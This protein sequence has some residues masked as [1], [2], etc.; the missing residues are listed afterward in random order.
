LPKRAL[1]AEAQAFAELADIVLAT[2][3]KR[4]AVEVAEGPLGR[5]RALGLFDPFVVACRAYPRLV[6]LAIRGGEIEFVTEA[7]TRSRDF[8]LGRKY[9]LQMQRVRSS[10]TSQLSAREEEVLD[11]VA[12]GRTNAEVARLLFISPVTVK[13]HLRHI[14]EKLG[15][16]NRVEAAAHLKRN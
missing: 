16:R 14:Y 8:D 6:E 11:L 2:N 5:I 4:D 3:S 9:G 7:L 1:H 13:A 10:G 12:S 15:V